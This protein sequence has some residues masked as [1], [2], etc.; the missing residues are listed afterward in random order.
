MKIRELAVAGAYR[1]TPEVHHD[2]RGTFVAP[3][4]REAFT[5]A[6]GRALPLGQSHH[7]VSRQGTVRGLHFADV[8]PGQAKLVCVTSGE[9]LDVVVDLRTG[10]PTFGHWDSLRLNAVDYEAVYLEEGLGHAFVALRDD[11]VTAYLNST[12]Y[13]PAVEREIDPFDPALGLPWPD[14]LDFLVSARDRAA[15]S[16]AEAER[17]GLLPSYEACLALRERR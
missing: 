5:A 1:I 3:Y 2:E 13:N 16:L 15:P 6:T 12:E 9:I 17:T 14:G 10:S 4:T 8:P 7:S 11:T